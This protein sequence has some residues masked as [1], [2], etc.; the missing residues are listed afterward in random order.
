M[1]IYIIEMYSNNID[2]IMGILDNKWHKTRE[3]AIDSGVLAIKN[4]EKLGRSGMY[5]Y[6]VIKLSE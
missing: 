6:N 2:E 5:S 4:D 3:S 1:D